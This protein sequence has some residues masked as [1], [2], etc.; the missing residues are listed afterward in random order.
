MINKQSLW[1][2]TLFSLILVLS[3]YYVTMPNE[4][5]LKSEVNGSNINNNL[6]NLEN[7]N[8]EVEENEILVA[9][10]V[11]LEEERLTLKKNLES[12]LT[13]SEATIDEKNEAYDKLTYLNTIFGDEERLEEKIKN[14][15][16]IECFI[17]INNNEI[18]VVAISNIHD[19]KLANNIMRSIQEEYNEKVYITVNFK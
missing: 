15:F 6:S 16:N 7:V 17:E 1:F 11:D 10:R 14:K 18:N 5:L 13:N 2:L 4:L 3:V 12:V 8:M 19:V 9:L